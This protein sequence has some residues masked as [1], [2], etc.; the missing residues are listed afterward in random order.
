MCWHFINNLQRF[1]FYDDLQAAVHRHGGK[2]KR[3]S[4][5]PICRASTYLLTSQGLN[6]ANLPKI[7]LKFH[8]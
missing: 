5:K 8:R 1:A 7:L 4:P 6:Y 2:V 3:I